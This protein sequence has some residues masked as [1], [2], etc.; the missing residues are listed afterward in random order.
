M[1]FPNSMN[2]VCGTESI[3]PSV[4]N[5]HVFSNVMRKTKFL[6]N[7]IVYYSF[8]IIYMMTYPQDRQTPTPLSKLF[9]NVCW[10]KKYIC[11]S[12]ILWGKITFIGCLGFQPIPKFEVGK[13]LLFRVEGAHIQPKLPS[14]QNI[15]Y[16]RERILLRWDGFPYNTSFEIVCLP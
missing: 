16:F 11:I 5:F 8:K 14:F 10:N 2:Y 4:V 7:F 12:S 9:S 13:W 3:K 6:S 1:S 15:S